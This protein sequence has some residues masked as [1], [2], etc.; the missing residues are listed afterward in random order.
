MFLKYKSTIIK[1]QLKQFWGTNKTI[2][3]WVIKIGYEIK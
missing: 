3:K 1:K 2:N